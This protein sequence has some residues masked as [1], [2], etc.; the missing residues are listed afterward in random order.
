MGIRNI[1]EKMVDQSSILQAFN[2]D[3]NIIVGIPPSIAT[4]ARP[5][6][7]DLHSP[8]CQRAFHLASE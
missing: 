3:G 2:K 4:G 5:K 6:Q 7:N 1:S 8:G